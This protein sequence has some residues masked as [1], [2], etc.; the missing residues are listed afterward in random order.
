MTPGDIRQFR[1]EFRQRRE[2][3]QRLRDELRREGVDVGDLDAVVRDLEGLDSERLYDD[4]EEVQRLQEAI[5]RG[6][7]DFEFALRRGLSAELEQ[8]FL[9]GSDDVP[10]EY[11][12]L[13]E[14]YYRAL[15]EGGP[16]R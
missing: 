1:S 12:E 16:P 13:V 9:S 2:D 10:P 15:S 7:K 11:R 3:A 6:L 14:E 5:L 8:L 4:P